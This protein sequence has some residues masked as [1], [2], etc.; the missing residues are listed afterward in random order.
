M[1]LRTRTVAAP[2]GKPRRASPVTDYQR[3]SALLW[4]SRDG[5]SEE[6]VYNPDLARVLRTIAQKYVVHVRTT[7]N[8]EPVYRVTGLGQIWAVLQLK[9][10]LASTGRSANMARPASEATI[11]ERHVGR[12][13]EWRVVDKARRVRTPWLASDVRTR[14]LEQ[15]A[16]MAV[17]RTD[18]AKLTSRHTRDGDW[19]VVHAI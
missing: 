8:D 6:V 5:N 13:G 16:K 18:P 19:V 4:L 15:A 12:S 10:D 2:R 11:E 3:A 7:A 17:R 14:V 1:T 9:S